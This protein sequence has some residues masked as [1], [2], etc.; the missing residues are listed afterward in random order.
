MAVYVVPQGDAVRL[1]C[2]KCMLDM[3]RKDRQA[4]L[5][6]VEAA[7]LDAV[8]SLIARFEPAYR[9]L[10]SRLGQR[11]KETEG[12]VTALGELQAGVR[13]FWEVGKR[14]VARKKLSTALLAYY[15][16]GQDGGVPRSAAE[17]SWLDFGANI[18]KGDAEAIAAGYPAMSNPS[19]VEIAD[20]LARAQLEANQVGGTD[21][22]LDTAQ[23]TVS[24]MRPEVDALIHEV[25][26]Q[27]RYT[28]RKKDEPSQRRIMRTYGAKFSYLP[29]ETPDPE[30]AGGTPDPKPLEPPAA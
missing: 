9:N 30:D 18:V 22:A 6:F 12:K 15:G 7:T 14:M 13:D 16:L 5:N 26:E 1:F 21:R 27:L 19:A 20:L 29:G 3:G 4:G 28:L 2:L 11:I 23:E 10:N 17:T 24:L 25:M 8:E